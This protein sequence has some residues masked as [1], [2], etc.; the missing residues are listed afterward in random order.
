MSTGPSI[1]RR[2]ILAL[3]GVSLFTLVAVGVVFY[4]FVGDYV[5]DRQRDLLLD[6]AVEVAEQVEGVSEHLPLAVTG[7]RGKAMLTRLLLADL[8]VLPSGSGIVVFSGRRVIAKVGS[9]PAEVESGE[10]LEKLRW[11]A[12]ELGADE[13]ASA[14]LETELGDDKGRVTAIVAVAPI[15]FPDG[16]TGL[17]VVTL[18]RA[19]AFAYRG[20]II[21]TL[22]IAGAVAVGL[23]VLVGSGL[24]AWMT[25]PL[26]RLL[27]AARGMAGGSY[28]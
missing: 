4:I 6:Q 2:L 23:A 26:R 16:Q 18:A 5:I 22:L 15:E 21:R 13:P 19:D 20:G 8:R 14:L 3:G 28:E 10:R 1:R 7:V 17:A 27:S 9:L 11:Q 25:R 12:E 24:G